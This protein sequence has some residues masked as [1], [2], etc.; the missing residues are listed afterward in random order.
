[1]TA[2][3][4]RIVDVCRRDSAGRTR[5]MFG[6][7]VGRAALAEFGSI[8]WRGDD[9]AHGIDV[10]PHVLADLNLDQIFTASG[11]S[12]H[13][14]VHRR[15]LRNVDSVAHRHE[16][17]RDLEDDAVR[18]AFDAF[19]AGMRSVREHVKRGQRLHHPQQ[20]NRWQLDA[21]AVYCRTLEELDGALTALP[22]CSNGL[23][24]WRDWLHDYVSA[25]PY[26]EL[27]AEAADVRADLESVR[28]A[29]HVTGRELVIDR[30][31]DQADYS[32]IIEEAF[33]RFRAGAVD[34]RPPMVDPW[35]D[36]NEVEEQVIALV[37]GQHP[38]PFRRLEQHAE[39]YRDFI[40]PAVTRFDAELQFYL[41]YLRFVRKLTALEAPFC[42]PEVTTDFADIRVDAAYDAALAIR[43]A[44]KSGTLVRN[45]FR[46]EGPERIIVVTGPNQGGKSTFARMFG[47]LF[48]LAALGCPVPAVRARVLLPDTLFTHFVHDDDISDPDGALAQELLRMRDI[49]DDI[50]A[51][52]V[53]VLNESFS[54]T[55]AA[56]A[57]RI[58]G[59][60]VRRIVDRGAVALYVTFLDELAE[61]GPEVV[62]MVAGVAAGDEAVRTFRIERRPPDGL[63]YAAAVA[64]RHGLTYDA[65]R[66]RLR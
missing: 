11:G 20:R 26:R 61:L 47:Q 24:H 31:A 59:D 63:A 13:E 49:V 4:P 25:V 3:G 28:Y 9:E 42:Y 44:G 15:P 17:F 56:D 21:E 66:A 23:R 32:A 18:A 54:T 14:A 58:G 46:L 35:P 37:A 19:T 10:E 5:A 29:V 22:L 36:M 45:D 27:V 41:D 43:L 1:M 52:S 50:T 12:A 57:L 38:R 39:R 16:I 53:V 2:A 6:A 40:A 51:R 60:V 55:A 7:S 48:Y 33:A 34:S 65:I 62:S 64:E 8:L 30:Y